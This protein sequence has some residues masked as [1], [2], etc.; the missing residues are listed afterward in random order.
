VSSFN[1]EAI[2]ILVAKKLKVD[3]SGILRFVPLIPAAILRAVQKFA[4]RDDLRHHVLTDPSV[5]TVAL[6]DEGAA[7]LSDLIDDP[8]IVLNLMRFGEIT[9]PSFEFPLRRLETAAQSRFASA[10]DALFP[11]Y[12]LEGKKLKTRATLEGG[13]ALSGVLGLSVPYWMTL[14]Q[15]PEIVVV[16]EGVG[17]VDSLIELLAEE[18]DGDDATDDR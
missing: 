16:T 15:V 1:E 5:V 18:A 7:D 9:H 3:P 11:K 2:A 6:D 13:G 14:A 8:R 17:V 12:W 10:L 4:G